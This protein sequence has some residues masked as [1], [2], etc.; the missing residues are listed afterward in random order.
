M[1][2]DL[3]SMPAMTFL[4]ATPCKRSRY[5]AA[6][7]PSMRSGRAIVSR[8]IVIE[9]ALELVP[10]ESYL[11]PVPSPLRK[12]F[13]VRNP[14]RLARPLVDVEFRVLPFKVGGVGG[15]TSSEGLPKVLF[16]FARSRIPS[17]KEWL[18]AGVELAE[19]MD[20]LESLRM[21]G[22]GA[23]KETLALLIAGWLGALR[24]LLLLSARPESVM[25]FVGDS[26]LVGESDLCDRPLVDSLGVAGAVSG[27]CGVGG[28]I[29]IGSGNSDLRLSLL[30]KANRDD[31]FAFGLTVRCISLDLLDRSTG[32][33]SDAFEGRGRICSSGS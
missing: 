4:D 2:V 14:P 7:S 13:K 30:G 17:R 6:V 33:A 12:R 32:G 15:V 3:D 10:G 29:L 18:A 23:A 27:Y 28:S 21:R 22:C 8:L 9:L 20:R 1:S 31:F 26:I 5:L 11:Y 25:S 24:R 16:V 19:C